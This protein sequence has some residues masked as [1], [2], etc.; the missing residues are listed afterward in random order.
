MRTGLFRLA[1]FLLPLFLS[2]CGDLPTSTRGA[3]DVSGAGPMLS[4]ECYLQDGIYRCPPQSPDWGDCDE[5]HYDCG[6]DDCIASTIPGAPG[7][8]T[9]QG[10]TGGGSGGTIGGGGDGG[11]TGGGG[12]GGGS[13]GPGCPDFGCPP[14]DD[15]HCD[16]VVDANCEQPL[17]ATDTAT[18]NGALR[19]Q[20]RPQSQFTDTTAAR[21]CGEMAGWFREAQ[22][23]GAVFR[24]SFDSDT[25]HAIGPHYGAYDPSTRHI[26]YDPWALNAANSGDATA[27]REAAITAFHEAAHRAGYNHPT[28]PTFDA[29]GRDFYTD[30]PFS[31]LNPGPNS[32]IPR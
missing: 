2:A 9:V 4:G 18:I 6:G 13:T 11:G 22:A 10:C 14:P 21:V 15:E 5:Y 32:C 16:P 30:F 3:P 17:T 23:A 20:P 8:A 31:H 24:G 12:G 27:I 1:A 26:H 19:T 25:T 29:Q 28:A 7:D